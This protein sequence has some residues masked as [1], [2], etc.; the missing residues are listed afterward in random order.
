[1]QSHGQDADKPIPLQQSDDLDE[2]ADDL[3]EPADAQDNLASEIDQISALL[4]A[5]QQKNEES[6]NQ[7]KRA[8]ADFINYRRR[9]GKE[10]DKERIAARSVLVAQ[11][12]PVLDDLGRAL[13]AVPSE[14]SEHPWVQGL[15]LIARRF[16]TQLDQIGV[17][18]IGASGEP[19]DPHRHEAILTEESSDVPEGTVVRVVQPGYALAERIIRPAQVSV[20]VPPS[21][22]HSM[23]TQEDDTEF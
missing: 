9:V 22:V 7:L 1:M 16:S 18:Q 5:E 21:P 13:N 3:D 20:A 4:Q 8:Q 15:S 11:L 6:L 23:P 10:Q 17:K 2:Q 12:L 19:F 14:L